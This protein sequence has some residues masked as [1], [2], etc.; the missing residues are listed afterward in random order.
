MRAVKA[1]DDLELQ[2]VLGASALLD[3]FGRVQTLIEEDGFKP[4]FTFHNI[5]E[6]ENPTTMAKSA[7]LGMIEMATV[8][9]NL[10]PDFVVIV[11]DRFEM[12]AVTLAAA[13]MNVRV[14]HTMGGEVTGTIDESIRHAITKFAHVHFA[15]NE[16]AQQR[17]IKMGEEATY[18]Y[19]TGCPRIDLVSEELERD[20]HEVLRERFPHYGGVGVPLDLSQPFLLASQ[21]PVTTEYGSSREQIEETLKALD[22][23][24]MQT[25]MLWPN[26]DAGSDDVS[27]GIRTFREHNAPSWL[28]VFKNLPTQVYIHLMRT[29]ACLVGN[30]SSGIRESGF[31]GTPVINVGTRQHLRMH[32]DNVMN[33]PY[34]ATAI[35][36]GITQQ[37]A[38]GRYERDTLYGDG[39]AGPK[40]AEILSQVS[41]SIQKTITY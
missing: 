29:T 12:M 14:A 6:G 25:I 37:I 39:H 18:V 23:L 17:I 41:P 36:D 26:I 38:H 7:G 2:V 32:A 22:K 16:D 31:I 4:D 15:A 8:L 20:S 40:M 28:H 11:G 9:D 13:Y 35:F 1:R 19:N 21:H 10:K 30:S 3:R 5:V 27:K 34:D 24:K 33:V